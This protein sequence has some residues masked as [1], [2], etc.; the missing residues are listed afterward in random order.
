LVAFLMASSEAC[1]SEDVIKKWR[2]DE[3]GGFET[4]NCHP[5]R[6]AEPK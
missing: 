4:F 1:F 2:A 6:S 3:G 5:T